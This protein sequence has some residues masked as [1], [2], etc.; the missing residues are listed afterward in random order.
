MK[1]YLT[2]III[3]WSFV[4]HAQYPSITNSYIQAQNET[5][6]HMVELD[7]YH[8]RPVA[9]P[10]R[11]IA[12]KTSGPVLLI[13]DDYSSER[14]F[15]LVSLVESKYLERLNN[16]LDKIMDE[17]GIKRDT[18]YDALKS[19]LRS[20]MGEPPPIEV[21]VG[22]AGKDE[23]VIWELRKDSYD[24]LWVEP[25]YPF[26]TSP[27]KVTPEMT[28]IVF[29]PEQCEGH[30][31]FIKD[32]PEKLLRKGYAAMAKDMMPLLTRDEY[33]S[34]YWKKRKIAGIAIF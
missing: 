26:A 9:S 33:G 13:A 22:K 11:E 3:L 27:R 5:A 6:R 8:A 23:E 20:I 32:S 15:D 28:I 16:E 29:F 7:D 24:Y 18:I 31:V 12:T 30:N 14:M 34:Y 17:Q 10:T 2:V 21:H 1:K 19:T 25:D 4:I